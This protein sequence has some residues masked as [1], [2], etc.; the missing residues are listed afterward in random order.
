MKVENQ[1]KPAPA[2]EAKDGKQKFKKI[3]AKE[4]RDLYLPYFLCFGVDYSKQSEKPTLSNS[5][6]KAEAKKF[7]SKLPYDRRNSYFTKV[8]KVSEN[9]LIRIGDKVRFNLPKLLED[10][11]YANDL[12]GIDLQGINFSGVSFRGTN[13]ER[14]NMQQCTFFTDKNDQYDDYLQA[15][16]GGANFSNT[17]MRGA[18]IE[19]SNRNVG[20]SH[21]ALG[22]PEAACNNGQMILNPDQVS[23]PFKTKYKHIQTVASGGDIS[24][25]LPKGNEEETEENADDQE[26]RVGM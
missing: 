26:F 25:Y 14:V 24:K 19:F 2:A 16:F 11:G 22:V 13:L 7:Y 23:G 10:N 5:G 20:H 4:F 17:D 3:T 18:G 21:S 1:E 12:S 6:K 9:Y 15:N 8:K